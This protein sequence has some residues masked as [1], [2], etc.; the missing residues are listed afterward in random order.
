MHV[1]RVGFGGAGQP[2]GRARAAAEEGAVVW[3]VGG[4]WVEIVDAAGAEVIAGGLIGARVG[5]L[6]ASE[7]VCRG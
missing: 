7:V 3:R 4:L 6:E 5:G 2:V 1:E